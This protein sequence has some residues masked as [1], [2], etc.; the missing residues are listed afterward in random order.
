GGDLHGEVQDRGEDFLD[1]VTVV[2]EQFKERIAQGDDQ[3]LDDRGVLL[4][5]V[6]DEFQ[7][8]APDGEEL[9]GHRADQTQQGADTLNDPRDVR[10]QL[11]EAV[12]EAVEQ[13]TESL[14]E[15]L[16]G[17]AL[18]D[19]PP[20]L[21][22]GGTH[23]L[24]RVDQ[25]VNEAG[26]EVHEPTVNPVRDGLDEV[27]R[28]LNKLTVLREEARRLH[29]VTDAGHGLSELLQ[30]GATSLLSVDAEGVDDDRQVPD[31]SP[32][33][34]SVLDSPLDP[35]VELARLSSLL[36][37]LVEGDH[38]PLEPLRQ[39]GQ[40][41]RPL[42]TQRRDD[43]REGVRSARGDVDGLG[44]VLEHAAHAATEVFPQVV[45]QLPEEVA[46]GVGN[47]EH[48]LLE[49]GEQGV[50]EVSDRVLGLAPEPLRHPILEVGQALLDLGQNLVEV[51]ED[52]KRGTEA[53]GEPGSDTGQDQGQSPD[54]HQ[55]REQRQGVR[56]RSG[57][58]SGQQQDRSRHSR[59]GRDRLVQVLQGL[60]QAAHRVAGQSST[61]QCSNGRG[62]R[63]ERLLRDVH[64]QRD[65]AVTGHAGQ[66]RTGDEGVHSGLE[67]D[68]VAV[69]LVLDALQLAVSPLGVNPKVQDELTL[70]VLQ[71]PVNVPQTLP[72]LLVD[73]NINI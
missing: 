6:G 35:A 57:E 24:H 49:L 64:V 46:Q 38:V 40:V 29:R 45:R 1:V 65:D 68:L 61:G 9:I 4:Q 41:L 32:Q 36:D 34:T 42:L 37:P 33:V 70:G 3:F 15:S 47:S 10:G 25:V 26:N 17:Q 16:G 18:E 48:P 52:G 30:P 69:V 7:H 8:L 28:R 72:H 56:H 14:T 59:D 67:L 13:A 5:D 19:G 2:A 43:P 50:D 73:I 54:L 44:Q 60:P 27:V 11:L 12:S 63:S 22:D 21:T 39:A 51:L 71:H 53:H 58:R 23:L 55:R 66:L 62:G 31:R 20:H